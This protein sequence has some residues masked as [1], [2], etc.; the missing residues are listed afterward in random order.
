MGNMI[1]K[2]QAIFSKSFS[3]K[4]ATLLLQYVN[5]KTWV[6]VSRITSDS[7]SKA[8]ARP[9]IISLISFAD[10]GLVVSDINCGR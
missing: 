6:E 10:Y 8:K 1:A 9:N 3:F 4:L 7:T 2:K 5:K